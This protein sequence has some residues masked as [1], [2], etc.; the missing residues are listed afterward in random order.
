M[1]LRIC[2]NLTIVWCK[3]TTFQTNRFTGDIATHTHTHPSSL[4]SMQYSEGGDS[5]AHVRYGTDWHQ[6]CCLV[7]STVDAGTV[8]LLH[9]NRGRIHCYF[10]E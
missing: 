9:R 1:K 3:K 8:V 7:T 5:S 10:V 2:I 4:K 6:A